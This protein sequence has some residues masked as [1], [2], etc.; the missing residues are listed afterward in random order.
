MAYF[1]VFRQGI[2]SSIYLGVLVQ[3][4]GSRA[5]C[6]RTAWLVDLL[7]FNQFSNFLEKWSQANSLAQVIL[8]ILKFYCGV[9]YAEFG[10]VTHFPVK[11]WSSKL[12][13]VRFGVWLREMPLSCLRLLMP[14]CDAA[15]AMQQNSQ[16]LEKI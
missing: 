1:E 9:F 3:A 15:I 2:S 12:G 6:T 10:G 7:F 14:Q 11:V 8:N 13:Q 4:L 16:L 5:A